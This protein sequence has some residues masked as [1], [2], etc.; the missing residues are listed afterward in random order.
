MKIMKSRDIAIVDLIINLKARLFVKFKLSKKIY[1]TLSIIRKIIIMRKN[2][3]LK[4]RIETI[5]SNFYPYCS[6]VYLL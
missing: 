4:D 1:L 6:D 2:R 5:I 3:Q